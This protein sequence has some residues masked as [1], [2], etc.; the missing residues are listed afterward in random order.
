MSFPVTIV[1]PTQKKTRAVAWVEVT[2]A[3]GNMVILPNHAPFVGVLRP[4]SPIAW[5]SEAGN[6]EGCQLP[7]GFLEV[8]REGVTIITDQA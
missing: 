6:V 1:T 4:Q 2:V 5:K 3:S 8:T 7:G